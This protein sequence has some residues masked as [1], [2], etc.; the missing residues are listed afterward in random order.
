MTEPEK[1]PSTKKRGEDGAGNPNR[2]ALIVAI[3]LIGIIAIAGCVAFLLFWHNG[4]EKA[5]AF[6]GLLA[7]LAAISSSI[8]TVIFIYLTSASLQ[9]AQ[10]GIDL[11]REE[12]EQIKSSVDLQRKEWEQ[13]VRVVPKFWVTNEGTRIWYRKN[14]ESHIAGRTVGLQISGE[15]SLKIWNSSEQSFLVDGLWIERLDFCG[16]QTETVDYLQLVL[17]PQ[18]VRD[19]DVSAQVMRLLTHTPVN[20]MPLGHM[21]GEADKK[22]RLGF[23]LRFS[24]WSQS[25][26]ETEPQAFLFSYE[27]EATPVKIRVVKFE[28]TGLQNP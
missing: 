25:Q 11:Q 8:V 5:E 16:I 1:T 13:K 10:A 3:I 4:N 15:F 24:D 19:V 28:K 14:S 18:S 17:A 2:F 23:A 12:L 6:S 26:V 21:A 20:Y 7:F 9:K 22:A 27:S